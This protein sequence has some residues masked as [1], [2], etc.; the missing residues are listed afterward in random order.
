MENERERIGAWI[1]DGAPKGFYERRSVP[2]REIFLEY[3]SFAPNSDLTLRNFGILLTDLGYPKI[4]SGG[5]MQYSL[6]D[7]DKLT[8]RQWWKKQKIGYGKEWVRAK[9]IYAAYINCD[10]TIEITW[11]Y[12][13]IH[14]TRL[15]YPRKRQADGMYYG[16]SHWPYGKIYSQ[17]HTSTKYLTGSSEE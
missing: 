10:N 11:K 8:F 16:L 2:V 14:L 13:G 4:K 5:V 9:D 3:L 7:P 12:V 15:K 1:I 17:W 6:T